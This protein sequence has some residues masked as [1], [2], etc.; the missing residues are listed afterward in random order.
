[1]SKPQRDPTSWT[2]LARI[3]LLVGALLVGGG[4]WLL[5]SDSAAEDV[6]RAT[7]L[8]HPPLSE[9]AA[10]PAGTALLVEGQLVA[11]EKPGPQGFLVYR[12]DRFVR[13]HTSGAQKGQEEWKTMSTV[14]PPFALQQNE[15]VIEVTSRDYVMKNWPHSWKSDVVPRYRSMSDYSERI[16]GFK[17]GDR[18]LVDGQLVAGRASG[19]PT[20]VISALA[21]GDRQAYL[22]DLRGGILAL[23]IVGAVFAGLGLVL[24]TVVALWRRAVRRRA[25]APGPA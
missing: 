15:V 14:T 13:K 5:L 16:F 11:R 7:A 9:L 22:E 23:K 20:L 19:K 17:A 3:L 24:L 8:P 6:K 4:V 10:L 12:Q 2:L 18:V 25:V 21:F 1:M